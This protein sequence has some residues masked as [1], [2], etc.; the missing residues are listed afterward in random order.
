[1]VLYNI[2]STK[3]K[4]QCEKKKMTI[5]ATTAYRA[6]TQNANRTNSIDGQIAKHKWVFKNGKK[7]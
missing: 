4:D 5:M 1:M 7:N 6:V 3:R 2:A